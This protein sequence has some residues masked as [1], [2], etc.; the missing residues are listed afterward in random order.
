MTGVPGDF[1]VAECVDCGLGVTEPRLAGDAI[2]PYYGDGYSPY[3]APTGV[4]VRLLAAYR[5]RL[6]SGM[7]RRGLLGELARIGPGRLLDVGCGR[8]DL[9]AAFRA[10]GWQVSGLDPSPAAAAAARA[11][12]VDARTG[13]IDG[14]PWPDGS[15]DAV[16][17]NHSLEHIPDPVGALEHAAALLR[18]R[19]RLFV[20]VP[21]WGSWQR[22]AFGSRWFHLE[23]PRHLQHFHGAALERAVRH[24]SFRPRTVR[25]TTSSAGLPA[26]IQYLL[27]GR[28]VATGPWLRL[29][30][31][32][33]AVLYPLTALIGHLRGG[34]TIE[35][36]AERVG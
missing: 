19:G 26:S 22:K 9:A 15:F 32:L 34:D 7:V 17:F 8:G 21:D 3:I 29:A 18:P 31:A 2:A 24:A 5:R 14:A 27:F 1:S 30:F 23:L 33:I 20:A 35:L 12:G 36:L 11:L 13:F 4:I 28:C 6:Y 16:I 25:E 10:R